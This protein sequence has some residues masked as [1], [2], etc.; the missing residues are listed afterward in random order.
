MNQHFGILADIVTN[1][2]NLND[3]LSVIKFITIGALDEY[4]FKQQEMSRRHQKL[5]DTRLF[6]FPDIDYR[7]HWTYDGAVGDS[8]PDLYSEHHY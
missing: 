2:L 1:E 6:G 4:I 8:G 3:A 7:V 5:F